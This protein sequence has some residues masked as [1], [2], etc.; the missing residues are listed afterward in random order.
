MSTVAERIAALN[1]KKKQDDPTPIIRKGISWQKPAPVDTNKSDPQP[2]KTGNAT[3]PNGTPSFSPT[4]G[5]PTNSWIKGATPG[6]SSTSPP[7]SPGV[8]KIP[9]LPSKT[10]VASVVVSAVV[11]S[12]SPTTGVSPQMNEVGQIT[13][14]IAPPALP[15]SRQS[16]LQDVRAEDKTMNPVAPS[17]ENPLLASTS[18]DEREKTGDGNSSILYENKRPIEKEENTNVQNSSIPIVAAISINDGNTTSVH[19]PNKAKVEEDILEIID[20]PPPPP[21]PIA[22]ENNKPSVKF[23]DTIIVE[24][25]SDD[26]EK[27]AATL[28]GEESIDNS[29]VIKTDGPEANGETEEEKTN[30]EEKDATVNANDSA[31]KGLGATGRSLSAS[32]RTPSVRFGMGD[33]IK[34]EEFDYDELD[35]SGIPDAPPLDTLP[36]SRR[37][38][39]LSQKVVSILKRASRSKVKETT[40][41]VPNQKMNGISWG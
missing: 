1:A 13:D 31:G 29:S 20:L 2:T 25:D 28:E 40:D 9:S 30:F 38:S 37:R 12:P 32:S 26:S 35:T 8:A 41:E 27:D 23:A 24:E 22:K 19:Q 6:N 7:Q 18:S 11:V 33:E 10:V 14:T 3:S 21:P 17:N 16:S 4:G 39:S 36:Q 5:K 15:P 34:V